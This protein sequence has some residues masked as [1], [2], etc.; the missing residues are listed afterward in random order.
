MNGT[1]QKSEND[2]PKLMVRN[3]ISNRIKMGINSNES[4]SCE[5]PFQGALTTKHLKN[6]ESYNTCTC[7]VNWCHRYNLS[8][9]VV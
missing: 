6:D 1:T 4:S 2:V 5:K 9:P 3:E 7:C 8:I